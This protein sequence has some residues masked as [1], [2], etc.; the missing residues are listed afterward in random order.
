MACLPKVKRNT[1]SSAKHCQK[2]K[3]I[4]LKKWLGFQQNLKLIKPK[5]TSFD[6]LNSPP[7]TYNP[8]TQVTQTKITKDKTYYIN[9]RSH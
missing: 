9:S 4:D 8:K 2:N 7:K 3:N 5:D 1:R 6:K